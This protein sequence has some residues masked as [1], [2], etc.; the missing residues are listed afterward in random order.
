MSDRFRTGHYL[1]HNLELVI[2]DL[3]AIAAERAA[4]YNWSAGS[5]WQYTANSDSSCH[6]T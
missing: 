5:L 2:A 3:P 4:E 6:G 1:D